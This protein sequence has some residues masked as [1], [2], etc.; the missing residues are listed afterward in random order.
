MF[1]IAAE[2]QSYRSSR[3]TL[4]STLHSSRLVDPGSKYY[5]VPGEFVPEWL[6]LGLLEGYGPARRLD[7]KARTLGEGS[8]N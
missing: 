3:S 6:L 4:L 1:R 7:T 2:K 5:R 8:V